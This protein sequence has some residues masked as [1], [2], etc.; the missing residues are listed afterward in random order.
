MNF[1][2]KIGRVGWTEMVRPAKTT[3]FDGD[4]LQR[5]DV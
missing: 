1:F 5:S 3:A 2:R 4:S